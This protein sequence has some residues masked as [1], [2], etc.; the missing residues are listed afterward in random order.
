LQASS[1]TGRAGKLRDGAFH[2]ERAEVRDGVSYRSILIRFGAALVLAG[3][4][5][6]DAVVQQC[7]DQCLDAAG[8]PNGTDGCPDI[9]ESERELSTRIDC[10]NEYEAMLDCIDTAPDV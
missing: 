2:A 6:S 1:A 8:C 5:P 3:C 7:I 9:C 10:N 4:G